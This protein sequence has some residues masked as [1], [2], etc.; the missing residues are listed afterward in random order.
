MINKLTHSFIYVLNQDEALTFYTEKLGFE[1]KAN[2]PLGPGKK[3]ITVSPS[4]QPD[5]E[6]VL[7]KAME[8]PFFNAATAAEVNQLV[9]K[10]IL[11]WCVFE[12][13]DIYATYE[14]LSGQRRRIY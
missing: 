12:C 4:N 6:L 7:M 11:G 10:G 14:E 8:G 3:W 2:F 9:A 1:L 13:T 5:I